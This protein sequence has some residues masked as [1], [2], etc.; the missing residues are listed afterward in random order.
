MNEPKTVA[1]Y[2]PS[3][4]ADSFDDF[5][6]MGIAALDCASDRKDW[7]D[8]ERRIVEWLESDKYKKKQPD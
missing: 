1:F 3:D 7:S 5:V 6:T 2:I 4:L 8:A